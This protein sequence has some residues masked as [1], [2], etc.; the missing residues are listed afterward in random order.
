[1]PRRRRPGRVRDS[2]Q[3]V[4]GGPVERW[5]RNVV[6][7]QVHRHLSTVV[8]EMAHD[9]AAHGEDLRH[10]H[11][12]FVAAPQGPGLQQLA[13]GHLDER[14]TDFADVGVEL[15]ENRGD[16]RERLTPRAAGRQ[17]VAVLLQDQRP[18][19]GKPRE[20]RRQLAQIEAL[21]MRPPR[22]G[23]VRHALEQ[24][25]RRRRFLIELWQQR[26]A[27]GHYFFLKSTFGTV[28][29]SG[30]AAKYG[31]SLKPNRL[32]VMFAGKRRRAWLYCVIC[33]L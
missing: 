1:M 13:V 4:S 25:A 9:E 3:L 32:A 22:E 7:P 18:P 12:Y 20:V 17:V 8:Y 28:F 19:M 16:V 31:Y 26:V 29:A 30:G 2:R 5:Q 15:L 33:S 10:G 14:R 11:E 21:R 27:F 23:V 24:A 6:H